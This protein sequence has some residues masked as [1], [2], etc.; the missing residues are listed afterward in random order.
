MKVITALKDLKKMTYLAGVDPYSAS[1][2]T[3]EIMVRAYRKS[4]LKKE[5][6]LDINWQSRECYWWR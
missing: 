1:K 6:T 4:F 3:T 2:S 5:K